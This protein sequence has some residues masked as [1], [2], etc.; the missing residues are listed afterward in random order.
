MLRIASLTLMLLAGSAAWAQEVPRFDIPAMCRAAPRLEASDQNTY[1]TCVRDETEARAQ[2]E[3]QWSGF[4]TRQRQTCVQEGSVEATPSYVQVLTCIQI[5][6]GNAPPAS[7][8]HRR[9]P[10]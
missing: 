3:R 8:R 10:P 7:A 2:L 9:A 5:A 1:Q 6:S 4:D